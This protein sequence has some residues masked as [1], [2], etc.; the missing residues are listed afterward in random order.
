MDDDQAL[1]RDLLAEP[2]LDARVQQA[3]ELLAGLEER[4]GTAS[5][6]AAVQTAVIAGHVVRGR[7]P[8]ARRLMLR[9]ADMVGPMA[10]AI[11][12][13]PRHGH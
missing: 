13:E 7:A 3:A 2:G 12:M 6:L 4:W 11:G 9:S 5:M 1:M 10:D 8:A